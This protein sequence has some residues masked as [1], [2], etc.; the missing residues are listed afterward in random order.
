MPFV[1]LAAVAA[2]T[3]YLLRVRRSQTAAGVCSP[4]AL[5][6]TSVSHRSLVGIRGWLVVYTVGLA[7]ALAHGLALTIGSVIVYARPSLVGLHSF[8]PLWALVIYV[9]S[10]V[11]L[12]AYGLTLFVLMTKGKRAAI[13]HNIAFNVLSVT[14]LFVWFLLSEKSPFGT[15]VDSLPALV[16]IAYF[17]RS[18]RVRNTFTA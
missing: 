18:R 15:V 4:V 2:T 3:L 6:S 13:A 17:A 8:I 9:V 14:F 5:R 1:F 7:A 12:V 11:G 16:G 10:N